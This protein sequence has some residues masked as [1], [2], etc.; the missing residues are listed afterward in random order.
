MPGSIRLPRSS[1]CRARNS[2]RELVAAAATN[3]ANDP[4]ARGAYSWATPRTRAAQAILARADGPVLFSGEALY[5][6]RD[7][8]N[9]RGGAGERPGDGGTD[10]AGI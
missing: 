4:F 1:A 9:G 3:W 7:M 8:G 5:R 10:L 6:G 2:T